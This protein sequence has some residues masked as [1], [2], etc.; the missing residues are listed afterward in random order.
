MQTLPQY[1]FGGN[2]VRVI[3]IGVECQYT[4][5]KDVHHIPPRCFHNHISHKGFWQTAEFSKH[6]LKPLQFLFIR[7]RGK[8][9]QICNLLKA[10]TVFGGKSAHQ[11]ADVIPA[12]VKL[13]RTGMN[14]SVRCFFLC[15]Y[16]GY[17]GKTGHNAVAA[18]IS[19]SPEHGVFGIHIRRNAVSLI[20]QCSK[21]PQIFRCFFRIGHIG[22]SFH[23]IR[24]VVGMINIKA[25]AQ[26]P[27]VPGLCAC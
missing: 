23:H 22:Y 13:T 2:I 16:G 12:I 1:I 10:K 21:P 20:R 7:K 17:F 8:E 3:V 9:Q 11:I 14:R 25:G 27:F 26:L 24:R 6:F 15:F 4:A 19:E 18:H 5:G